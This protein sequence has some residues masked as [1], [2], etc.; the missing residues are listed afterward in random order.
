MNFFIQ[1]LQKIPGI[2]NDFPHRKKAT[3]IYRSGLS[4]LK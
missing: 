4:I 1:N 3:A 2:C